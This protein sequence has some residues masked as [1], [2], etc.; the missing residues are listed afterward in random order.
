VVG[1][2]PCSEKNRPGPSRS[3]S[4]IARRTSAWLT[5]SH[6]IE[7]FDWSPVYGRKEPA[8]VRRFSAEVT[9]PAEFA[10]IL[11]PPEAAG[12]F[13]QTGPSAYLYKQPQGSHEFFFATSGACFIY[14]ANTSTGPQEFSI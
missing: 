8:F 3:Y 6:A 10:V 14:R 12:T 13:T 5:W 9:L 11:A 2:K 7:R 1:A 4:S